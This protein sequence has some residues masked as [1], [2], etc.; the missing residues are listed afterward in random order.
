LI[1][2]RIGFLALIAACFVFAP[3][4]AILG[5]GGWAAYSVATGL[6]FF[7][8]FVGI[9]SGPGQPLIVIGFWVAVAL[10]WAWISALLAQLMAAVKSPREVFEEQ[11][12]EN[13]HAKDN[14]RR[15][16]VAGWRHGSTGKVVFPVPE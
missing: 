8:A 13:R 12:K 14:R 7:A 5:Q 15:A 3:R 1:S 9:A 11:Q 10:A 4:F 6:I 2:G 16:H